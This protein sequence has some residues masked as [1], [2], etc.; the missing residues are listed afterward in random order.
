MENIASCVLII[1]VKG[2]RPSL[3][4]LLKQIHDSEPNLRLKNFQRNFHF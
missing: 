3:I 2:Q 4:L 1:S